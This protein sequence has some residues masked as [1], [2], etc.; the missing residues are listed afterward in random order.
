[1]LLYCIGSVRLIEGTF[2]ADDEAK[3]PHYEFE[4]SD[5]LTSHNKADILGDGGFGLVRR[6]Q[7]DRLGSVAVKCMSFGG[8]SSSIVNNIK[9]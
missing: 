4:A 2:Y 8:S 3:Y 6:C 9:E 7:H 5:F 1:M